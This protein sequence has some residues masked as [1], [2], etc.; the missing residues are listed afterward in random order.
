MR[1]G[2]REPD[3][4]RIEK[5]LAGIPNKTELELKQLEANC[6]GNPSAAG[7]EEI[8]S[9][10]AAE[11]PTRA[12]AAEQRKSDA[13]VKLADRVRD[14]GLA[15]R[16]AL[17]CTEKPLSGNEISFLRALDHRREQTE[18]E[19]ARRAGHSGPRGFRSVVGKMCQERAGYL[20]PREPAET[21]GKLH[22]VTLVCEMTPP[23][24]AKQPLR[25][26]LR[27]EAVAAFKQLHILQT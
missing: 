14:M 13:G 27:P 17:A 18:D 10:I 11:G 4:G 21:D 20:P 2:P 8:L 5:I 15:E 7:V 22:W 9:A 16:L 12:R 26:S 23:T 19:I 3:A 24:A 1:P 25:W 6:R